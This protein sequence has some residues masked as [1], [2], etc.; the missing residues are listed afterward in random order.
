MSFLCGCQFSPLISCHFQAQASS[1]VDYYVCV[2]LGL[3]GREQTPNMEYKPAKVRTKSSKKEPGKKLLV[4][5]PNK[6]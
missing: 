5:H 6:D 3:L 1:E 4:A 2:G